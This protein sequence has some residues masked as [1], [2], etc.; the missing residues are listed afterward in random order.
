MHSPGYFMTHRVLP[1]LLYPSSQPIKTSRAGDII[2][3]EHRV[4]VTI[5]LLHHRLPKALL[6]CRVPQLE[7][8]ERRGDG[9]RK[10]KTDMLNFLEGRWQRHKYE[11]EE[12]NETES[13]QR[14]K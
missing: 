13:S 12:M 8:I 5:V 4:D 6:S 11:K 3:K 10:S 14:K 9:K 7:L 1:A 2:N